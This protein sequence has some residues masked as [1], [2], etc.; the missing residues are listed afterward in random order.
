MDS[1]LAA[2]NNP[3]GAGQA[4]SLQN[5]LGQVSTYSLTTNPSAGA[6]MEIKL[7]TTI[8]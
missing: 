3:A 1:N 6:G 8:L 2:I 7:I 4:T 5:V